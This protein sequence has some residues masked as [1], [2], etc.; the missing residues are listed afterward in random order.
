MKTLTF[1][2]PLD[3][4]STISLNFMIPASSDPPGFIVQF[5][6]ILILAANAPPGAKPKTNPANIKPTN[7]FV[8]IVPLLSLI[9]FAKK[10]VKHPVSGPSLASKNM[11]PRVKRPS[12]QGRGVQLF[13]IHSKTDS[14]TGT[15]YKPK[16]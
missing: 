2:L 5:T 10:H 15:S 12:P 1:I 11:A 8:F 3:F 4:A 7:N 16:P 13:S 6:S 9:V 14:W